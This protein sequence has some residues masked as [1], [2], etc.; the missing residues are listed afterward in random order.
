MNSS[1]RYIDFFS[2]SYSDLYTYIFLV[3]THLLTCSFIL[4]SVLQAAS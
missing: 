1:F 4:L 2:Y 3:N